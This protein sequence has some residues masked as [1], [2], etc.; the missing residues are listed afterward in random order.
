MSETLAFKPSAEAPRGVVAS[1]AR[2]PQ[3]A[4]PGLDPGW[5]PAFGQDHAPKRSPPDLK[6]VMATQDLSEGHRATAIDR[7]QSG[8][9]GGSIGMVLLVAIA[10]VGAAVGL[11]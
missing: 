8:S 7:S 6:L 11:L 10:L 2:D 1:R 5:G 3:K 9:R 4:C